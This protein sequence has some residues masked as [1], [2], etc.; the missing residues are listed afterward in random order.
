MFSLLVPDA[1]GIV[2]VER[3]SRALWI[4]IAEIDAG[5][6]KAGTG[7]L[8]QREGVLLL[9]HEVADGRDNGK[10]CC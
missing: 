1:I 7:G 10:S 4:S 3:F 5:F 2:E 8:W 6:L 9:D